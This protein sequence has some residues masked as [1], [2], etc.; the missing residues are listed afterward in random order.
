GVIQETLLS[1]GTALTYH[2]A[3]T[4]SIPFS[5]D[6]WFSIVNSSGAGSKLSKA[7]AI[8]DR[9]FFRVFVVSG[10]APALEECPFLIER[11][12]GA[13]GFADFEKYCVGA[14]APGPIE[15]F[16]QQTRAQPAATGRPGDGNIFN[17]P[18]PIHDSRNHEPCETRLVLYDQ[19]H[20]FRAMPTKQRL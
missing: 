8:Q 14:P 4:A 7:K 2:T 20:S 6:E 15:Q 11:P 10:A 5:T 19:C 18:F 16:S 1:V 13:V 17:L 12:G 9:I 3:P